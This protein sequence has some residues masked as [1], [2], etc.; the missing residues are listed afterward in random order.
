MLTC[1]TAPGDHDRNVPALRRARSH[2]GRARA[3]R[4]VE[5]NPAAIGARPLGEQPPIRLPAGARDLV[6]V[7]V[8]VQPL[9]L[10]GDAFRDDFEAKARP[11]ATSGS[12]PR[13]SEEMEPAIA[14]VVPLFRTTG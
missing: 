9:E 3:R 1:V 8:D 5:P 6:F 14:E 13:R 2:D 11:A 12:P 4:G 7:L 10:A